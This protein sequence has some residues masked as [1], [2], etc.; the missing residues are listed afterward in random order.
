[1][2]G[3]EI[4]PVRDQAALASPAAAPTYRHMTAP[5]FWTHRRPS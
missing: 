5:K 1:M 3:F 2:S 4:K